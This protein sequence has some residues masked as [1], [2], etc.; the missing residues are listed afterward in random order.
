MNREQLVT[1][2]LSISELRLR[3]EVAQLKGRAAELTLVERTR[4]EARDTAAETVESVVGLRDLGLIGE[5][6][7]ASI[8][9]A[10]AAAATVR[11]ASDRVVHAHQRTRSM[12]S[13]RETL[14]RARLLAAD[15]IQENDADQFQS[16]K[17]GADQ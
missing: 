8:K 1:R 10:A 12:R 16:W 15:R 9:Q 5:V 13:A 4:A 14:T 11:E 6:R 7:I 2:L 17:R 3:A